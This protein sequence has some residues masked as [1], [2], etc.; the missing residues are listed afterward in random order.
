M[1]RFGRIGLYAAVGCV[2]ASSA[3]AL[4]S[5]ASAGPT[6]IVQEPFTGESLPD[7]VAPNAASGDQNK[8]CQA[9]PNY[10]DQ[11][12]VPGCGQTSGSVDGLQLTDT[13]ATANG[14]NEEGGINFGSSVLT[15][16]GL[17]VNFDSYQYNGAD[18]TF[19]NGE[20]LAFFLAA[21]DPTRA[22]ASPVTLGPAG[23]S[24]GYLPDDGVDGLSNAYLGFGLDAHGDFTNPDDAV[25]DNETQ[26]NS[27]GQLVVRG[28]GSGQNGYCMLAQT[29]ATVD[30]GGGD[31]VLVHT[32]VAI[33][34]SN[35]AI[36]LADHLEVP[37][38][39]WA[40]ELTG[41]GKDEHLA[42]QLPSAATI[43]PKGWLDSNGI[44]TAL[45][46]GWA[47]ST[48]GIDDDAPIVDYNTIGNV[49]VDTLLGG[50]P[51]LGVTLADNSGGTATSGDTVTYTATTTVSSADENNPID[52]T[53]TFPTDLVPQANGL[54]GPGWS[55]AING[56]TVSCTYAGGLGVGQPQS[57][58]MPVLVDV[59]AN[60]SPASVPDTVMVSSSDTTS[61]S[62]THTQT[63][64]AGP[65]LL[66]VN[67]PV[68]SQVDQP[69]LN[70]DGTQT[71]VQVAAEDSPNGPVDTNYSGTVTLGF[72]NNP[73]NASFLSNGVP[74]STLTVQANKGVAD[75]SP[76]VVNAVG[77]GYTLVATATGTTS[78]AVST[79]F[80]VNSAETECASGAGCA[81][82]T[83]SAGTGQT[84]TVT[85]GPGAGASTL[86]A[87][88][89]GNVAPIHPCTT[90]SA[91]IL[92]MN[93]SRPKTTTLTIATR[94]PILLFCYGQ[95]T[96]F[97]DLFL[98]KTTFFNPVNQEFEGLLPACIPKLTLPGPCISALTLTRTS[99]TVKILSGAADPHISH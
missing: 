75:F 94:T 56:Q 1:R 34:P 27:P 89:G 70:G 85:E 66:F 26:A 87:S 58:S 62:A 98:H 44:P 20:G 39:G 31:P 82:T 51:Q 76:I 50:T 47:G 97:I 54:G 33:N 59:P 24:L 95:P 13:V 45:T 71:D 65:V 42:G 2:L 38:S 61:V 23:G 68:N 72:Q 37:A 99:E 14:G 5:A 19:F 7:W 21:S 25:C 92:T 35:T 22:T 4:P 40:V 80:D 78:S 3:V 30:S 67:E 11:T 52:L 18:S 77:F 29:P 12:P 46:F 10:V 36:E 48:G 90:T 28:P 64:S 79:P 93:G 69:M 16:A 32:E 91:G 57:V 43:L 84:A 8:A 15:S 17:D 60:A 9:S 88:F 49:T 6:V 55:C 81:V 73:S 53:D 83:T 86:T 74:T 96:P 63:Y 41:T